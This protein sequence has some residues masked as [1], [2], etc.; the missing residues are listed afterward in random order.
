MLAIG[1]DDP[2][3]QMFYHGCASV[4]LPPPIA[5]S[6]AP[7]SLRRALHPIAAKGHAPSHAG[8]SCAQSWRAAAGLEWSQAA[9][10]YVKHRKRNPADMENLR[11]F[12]N[13]LVY[14]L[15]RRKIVMLRQAPLSVLRAAK[16]SHN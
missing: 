13:R 3:L 12:F 14:P 11:Q 7:V 1:D 10:N 4:Y 8:K 5:S 2:Q 6:A 9:S 16:I 15:R